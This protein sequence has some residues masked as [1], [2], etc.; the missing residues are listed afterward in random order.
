MLIEANKRIKA[1]NYMAK[2]AITSRFRLC[3]LCIL[4]FILVI[5]WWLWSFLDKYRIHS[6]WDFLI[7][8]DSLLPPSFDFKL[9]T[10][11]SWRT[12]RLFSLFNIRNE[13]R[14]QINPTTTGR[15]QFLPLSRP[16]DIDSRGTIWYLIRAKE[17]KPQWKYNVLLLRA[18]K[19]SHG[20][21]LNS[22][23]TK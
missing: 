18:I 3:Y 15:A 9:F 21:T 1:N 7:S 11:F 4:G 20:K 10:T 12:W 5:V 23:R 8:T 2:I 6:T 22:T 14:H 19:W 13:G 16:G 17:L